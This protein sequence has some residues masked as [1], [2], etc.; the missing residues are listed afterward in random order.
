MSK[1][2]HVMLVNFYI[3]G[4][5]YQENLLPKFHKLQG[6][7]VYIVTNHN[8]W[9]KQPI[10]E[11]QDYTNQDGVN[12]TILS[13]R[14]MP[15]NKYFQIIAGI[16]SRKVLGFY[17]YLEKLKPEIVFVHGSQG[18][19]NLDV[20][21]YKLKNSFVRVFVDSHSD[22]YN[23]PIKTISNRILYKCIFRYFAKR[24]YTVCDTFW[25]VTPWRVD[26]LRDVFD[27]PDEKTKL[28][29]MG[30]DDSRIDYAHKDQIRVEFR[31][32]HNISDNEY[33]IVTGGKIDRAKNIHL[34]IDALGED[35]NIRL[36]VFGKPSNDFKSEIDNL[37]RKYPRVINVGWIDSSDVYKYFL[38]A[39]LVFFPGTHSV[40]WEQ[41]VAC[42]TPL[43]VKMWEGM[44]HVNIG[45]NCRFLEDVTVE[46]IKS[47]VSEIFRDDATDYK[48]M[49]IIAEGKAREYFLYSN[50]AKRAIG[51]D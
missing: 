23:T 45:G 38:A 29:V 26:Y 32:E 9:A 40:L 14:K 39:D 16:C 13:S 12:V 31:S 37:M 42:G 25:G 27:L 3:E 5:G 11:R 47:I 44:Q 48:K 1:I 46:S 7:E 28:L 50:I 41:A 8:D 19:D 35:N 34:L 17:K 21:K 4:A 33:V 36:A 15:K 20:V 51:N 18:V 30:G 43:V 2:L 6:H 10:F 22:Y 24:L 49:K